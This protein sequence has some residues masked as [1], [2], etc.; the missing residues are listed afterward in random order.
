LEGVK[1]EL[2]TE[3]SRLATLTKEQQRVNGILKNLQDR[4]DLLQGES[5][6]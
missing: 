3:I 6:N 4:L 5:Q 2:D 1:K